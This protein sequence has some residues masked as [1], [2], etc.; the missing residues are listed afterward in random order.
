M[1]QVTLSAV[2]CHQRDYMDLYNLRTKQATNPHSQCIGSV[3][4]AEQETLHRCQEPPDSVLSS[5]GGGGARAKFSN[6]F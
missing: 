1:I 2:L 5:R 3:A 6:A 4:T